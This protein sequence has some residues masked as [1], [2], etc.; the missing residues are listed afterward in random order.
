MKFVTSGKGPALAAVALL[1]AV[2]VWVVYRA[3]RGAAVVSVGAP[4]AG[5]VPVST[6][7]PAEPAPPAPGPVL[8]VAPGELSS[9]PPA[10]LPSESTIADDPLPAPS[11]GPA[12]VTPF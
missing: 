10:P 5:G 2:V 11:G 8:G 9:S 6:S 7:Q 12:P 1:V 3:T 4:A